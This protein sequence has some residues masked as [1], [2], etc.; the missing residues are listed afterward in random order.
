MTKPAAW[1]SMHN[2]M[3]VQITP[4]EWQAEL[5]RNAG[6]VVRELVWK[7]AEAEEQREHIAASVADMGIVNGARIAE[8]IRQGRI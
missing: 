6:G 7:E 4:W 1:A 2:G 5:W 8:S 3:I